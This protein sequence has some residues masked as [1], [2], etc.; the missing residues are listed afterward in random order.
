MWFEVQKQ[1]LATT[2]EIMIAY[3]VFL[4][5][6]ALVV[7]EESLM[8]DDDYPALVGDLIDPHHDQMKVGSPIECFLRNAPA[9]CAP[10]PEDETVSVCDLD[11]L[12]K[13]QV[14][15]GTNYRYG[16]KAHVKN[17]DIIEIS[18]YNK[19]DHPEEFE[20]RLNI[21]LSSFA[22]HIVVVRHADMA[23]LALYQKYLMRLTTNRSEEYK[24]KWNNY[25][26]GPKLLMKALTPER[27]NS[28]N[29]NIQLLIGPGNSLVG[30]ATSF[31]ND[32][33]TLLNLDKY[34]EFYAMSPDEIIKEVGSCGS[35]G[36][37]SACQGAWMAAKKVVNT[38]CKDLVGC[39]DL[40]ETDLDDLAMLVWT[41]TFYHGFIGDFQLDNSIKGNL[42]FL[43]TGKKHV[44][45]EAY[46]TL[47]TTIGASTMTRTMDMDTLGKYFAA[48]E[49]RDAWAEYQRELT[50]CAKETGIEGFTYEGAVY[51]AIDF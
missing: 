1:N 51:N 26:S 11:Y 16:G 4:K 2:A 8:N 42:P 32:G 50:A 5:A 12:G 9:F 38:I 40:K 37:N 48:K 7:D 25:K 22:V 15:S 34:D 43:L 36:W 18:G 28:I 47:A 41:G 6:P 19:K 45:S 24:D 23:H 29:W 30:R 3:D 27:T 14:K 44:Q 10:L 39:P 33:L 13:Y 49:D 21:F 31:T 35:K 46:A 17:G 20:T